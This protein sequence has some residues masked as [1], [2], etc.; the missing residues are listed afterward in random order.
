MLE[1]KTIIDK[2]ELKT[3][4]HVENMLVTFDEIGNEKL[5]HHREYKRINHH[6]FKYHIKVANPQKIS[7]KVMVRIWLGWMD[8]EYLM[9]EMDI[10]VTELKSKEVEIIER[11]SVQSSATMKIQTTEEMYEH[12]TNS[13]SQNIITNYCIV[14]RIKN[15]L[16]RHDQSSGCG[17]PHNLL[18][19]R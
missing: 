15:N 6:D 5:T 1:V 17:L 14:V 11:K 4:N 16:K 10:F 3:E 12:I 2:E 8:K 18:L 19:P 13:N 7:R 9:V